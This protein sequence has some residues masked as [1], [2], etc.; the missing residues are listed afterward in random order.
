MSDAHEFF[1]TVRIG[2]LGRARDLLAEDPSLVKAKEEGATPLHYA[3]LNNHEAMVDLLIANGADLD[4]LDD[5]YHM[6]PIAWANEK[7]HA[8]MV[9]Y[10]DAAGAK[11]NL[12]LASALGLADR[13][14][15]MLRDDGS[16]INTS[17]G[18]GTPIHLASLWGHAA[19]VEMLLDKGAN[20]DLKNPQGQ[21]ALEIALAQARTGSAGTPTALP[22]RRREIVAGCEAAAKLLQARGA[23]E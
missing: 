2:D 21:T 17:T 14:K 7:G 16:L 13:V 8:G 20:P 22:Q 4:A 12:H 11:L 18:F 5:V 3:A 10:L 1:N 19:V 23:K 6:A 15:Q 9:R